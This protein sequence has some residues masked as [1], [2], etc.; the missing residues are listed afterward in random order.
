MLSST[1]K[2]STGE[3]EVDSNISL[4]EPSRN[5]KNTLCVQEIFWSNAVKEE[6]R[7]YWEEL[8]KKINEQLTLIAYDELDN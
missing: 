3:L 6:I 8:R 7:C 5:N 1:N 4:E 2:S